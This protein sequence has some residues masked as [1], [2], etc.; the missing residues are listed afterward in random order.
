MRAFVLLSITFSLAADAQTGPGGVGTSSNNVLWLSAESGVHSNAGTVLAGNNDNVQQW[1]DRSGNG[2][3]ATQV[4]AGNRPNLITNALNGYPVI[5]YTAANNDRML[6]TGLSTANS[7]SVWV[8]ARY[9]SLPSSNPGLLQ[10]AASGNGYSGTPSDKNIGMWVSSSTT[11]VWGR[12]I[13]SDGTQ[14]NVT[15]STALSSGQAYVLNTMYRN[16]SIDQYVNHGAAGSVATDGTLRSWTDMSIGCQAGAE[17][18][19]GDIAEVV[20]FNAL[21]NDAQRLLVAN[22]LAAKYGLTLSA[23]DVYLQDNAGNGNFDHDVAGIGRISAS[24]LHTTARGSGIVEITKAAYA[25]LDNNEFLIW[26]HNNGQIGAWGVGDL[27]G[28]VQGRSG[29]VWR[30]SERNTAGSGAVEVGAVNISFDL[31]G[32]GPV[33]ASDLVLLVDTDNDGIFSDET[34]ISGAALISGATYQFTN[35]TALVDGRRFT[36]GT[37]NMGS[38]PLPIELVSF[39]AEPA[40]RNTV[41]TS[42]TTAS[43]HD[44]DHFVVERSMDGAFWEAAGTL[45]GAGFSN[46]M[47]RY[48]LIDPNAFGDVVYYRLRQ[49]DTDGTFT[50]SD[51]RVV[52]MDQYLNGPTL[53]PNPAKD[54]FT[55]AWD[56]AIEDGTTY[57]LIDASGRRVPIQTETKGPLTTG[58]QLLHPVPGRYLLRAIQDDR[59]LVSQALLVQ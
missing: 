2:K 10:G 6:S 38:T 9:S 19:N 48:E 32:L 16:S 7:A 44:N 52:R 55:V 53:F 35:V 46:S 33:T 23:N 22:Y 27:P 1:N 50:L 25:G 17:S 20:A 13:Q 57:E 31:I 34:P 42:W 12:G 49:T 11:Q 24:H 14:R 5:R 43:E 51:I 3:H 58:V 30:V 40:G 29:R 45:P 39:D 47:L 15:M 4:T 37:L 56:R 28:S 54:H 21:V 36:F 26:G 18:W 8:V 41:R 59:V